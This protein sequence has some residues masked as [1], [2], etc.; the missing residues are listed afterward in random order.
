MKQ[1]YY[2]VDEAAK[3]WSLEP[4]E[5]SS[6]FAISFKDATLTPDRDPAAYGIQT[7]Q[8]SVGN[9]SVE[10]NRILNKSTKLTLK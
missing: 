6:I 7:P 4:F 5:K 8:S 9:H 3:F 10:N 1:E 2:F